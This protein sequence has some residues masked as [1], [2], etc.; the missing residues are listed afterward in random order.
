[1]PK[2]G[3]THT[4]AMSAPTLWDA[5]RIFVGGTGGVCPFNPV[6]PMH[7]TVNRSGCKRE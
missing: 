1:M 4:N 6:S 3:G 2:A 5:V 7:T